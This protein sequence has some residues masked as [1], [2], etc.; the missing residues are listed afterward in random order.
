MATEP[1][2]FVK[3]EPQFYRPGKSPQLIEV[4]AM[5][6]FWMN[7]SGAPEDCCY[8]NAVAVLYSLSYTVKM[9]KMSGSTPPGYF[10]YSV[11]PLEGFWSAANQ[12]SS[13][14]ACTPEDRASWQWSA[15]IRQPDFVTDAVFAWALHTAAAKKPDLDFH[16]AEL[17]CFTEGLCLQALHIGPYAEEPATL[18]KM[19]AYMEANGLVPDYENGRRHHEIYLGDPR[20]TAPQRLK[21]ILRLPVRRA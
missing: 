12:S 5:R 10:E 4:P 13:L 16:T 19:A 20:R 1:Y 6:F 9:S 18:D 15:I 2:R 17:H 14:H 11:A 8:Q 7:G 21:T 3:A